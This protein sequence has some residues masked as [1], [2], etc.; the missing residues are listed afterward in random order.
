MTEP[1]HITVTAGFAGD[2]LVRF[3]LPKRSRLPLRTARR[4]G[5]RGN[6]A[7]R[8]AKMVSWES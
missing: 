5:S 7:L 1:A 6:G 4:T 2:N 3:L 8:L